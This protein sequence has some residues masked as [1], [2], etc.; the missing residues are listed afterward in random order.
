[1]AKGTT[2]MVRPFIAPAK[3]GA[4]LA[5][6]LARAHPVVGRAGVPLELE[7]MYVRCSVR[8]TSVGCERCRKVG[9]TCLRRGERASRRRSCGLR[10]SE[11]RGHCREHQ[12]IA[13]GFVC[14][15]ISLTH[16]VS[17]RF[18]IR[19]HLPSMA[20]RWTSARGEARAVPDEMSGRFRRRGAVLAATGGGFGPGRR[21]RGE[22]VV[23]CDW[24]TYRTRAEAGAPCVSERSDAR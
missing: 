24:M 1:M 20:R 2:Y 7:Q 10:A 5:V 15:A 8:A 9:E 11:L 14:P 21:V 6:A 23:D 17:S 22:R 18:I 13:S 19:L 16:A 4:R 3:I 12:R